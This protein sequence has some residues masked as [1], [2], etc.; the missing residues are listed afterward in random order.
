VLGR[1]VDFVRNKVL[2]RVL[3]VSIGLLLGDDQVH[4]SQLGDGKLLYPDVGGFLID[5]ALNRVDAL[6]SASTRSSSPLEVT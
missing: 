2:D 5:I 4:V 3:F 6:C 1:C